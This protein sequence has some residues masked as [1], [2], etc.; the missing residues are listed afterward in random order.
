MDDNLKD[1]LALHYVKGL[2]PSGVQ[3]LIDHFGSIEDIF[4]A[5]KKELKSAG[6]TD[7][8]CDNVLAFKQWDEVKLQLDQLDKIDVE[9]IPFNA[10]EF[11]LN[12]QSVRSGPLL[13]FVRCLPEFHTLPG[14]SSPRQ[15][16]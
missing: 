3:K 4:I 11:P 10:P 13:L 5:D 9:V 6:L 12:L 14:P 15:H 7:R 2:G 8:I 16:L 1:W